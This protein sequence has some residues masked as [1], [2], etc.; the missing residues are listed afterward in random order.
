MAG[1]DAMRTYRI[2]EEVSNPLVDA[3]PP[4]T[5]TAIET[6]TA[7]DGTSIA[8]ERGGRGPPLVL[9]HGTTAD[10]TRWDPLRPAFEQ[11]F[12][13]YAIDRRGRGVSGDSAEYALERE[14]EDIAA[15]VDSIDESVVLLGHSYGALC[16]LE[17]ALRTDNLR[18]LVLYEPP[19]TVSDHVTDTE[20]VL[21][22]MTAL[23][24]DG[25]SEQALE[26][27]FREIVGSGPRELEA[28]RSS[29][30][31]PARV[32]TVHTVVR[33]ERAEKGHEFD[34]ARFAG[35]TI[36]VLLL[37][38]DESAPFLKDATDVLNDGLPNSRIVVFTGHGHAVMNTAPELF[39]D[40]V[41]AFIQESS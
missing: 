3:S 39:V 25:E 38:G 16:S 5:D 20:D 13:V 6:V 9:V 34:A 8:Y 28:Y 22:E 23:M 14:A 41:L 19:L 17:A 29:P 40:E 21:D 36:P 24:D 31:W 33:E 7:A 12:T 30:D 10:H 37:S 15:V 32:N 4:D 2:D 27:F 1:D 18:K 26:L 11:H 35:L